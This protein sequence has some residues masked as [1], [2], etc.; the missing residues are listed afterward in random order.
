MRSVRTRATKSSL[1]FIIICIKFDLKDMF[2]CYHAEL[3]GVTVSF[4]LFVN[5]KI[6][7]VYA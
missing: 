1:N 3:V 7:V 2:R 5:D 6:S 4:A